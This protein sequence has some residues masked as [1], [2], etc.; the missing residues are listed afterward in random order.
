MTALPTS[1]TPHVPQQGHWRDR[2]RD[3]LGDA[4]TLWAQVEETRSSMAS[5]RSSSTNGRYARSRQEHRDALQAYSDCLL[6]HHRP[7]PYQLRDELRLLQLTCATD[8]AC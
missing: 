8:H 4:G 5:S 6:A 1:S 2:A 3:P 7:M